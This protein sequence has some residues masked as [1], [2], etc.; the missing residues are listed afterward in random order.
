MTRTEHHITSDTILL[1]L[2]LWQICTNSNAKAINRDSTAT[3]IFAFGLI[4]RGV[5]AFG[6]CS[7]GV[8]SFG[9]L[10]VGLTAVG[11]LALGVLGGM[12]TTALGFFAFG[13]EA[14]GIYGDGVSVHCLRPLFSFMQRGG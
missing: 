13:V 11:V 3:A 2:P 14:I 10:S 9:I 4:S 12:G 8:F 5:F 1:G 6:I 7:F